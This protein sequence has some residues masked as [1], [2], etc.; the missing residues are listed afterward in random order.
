MEVKIQALLFFSSI[1]LII[2]A[3]IFFRISMLKYFGFYEPDGYYHYSIIVQ[4]IENGFRFPKYDVLSG[5]P[6]HTLFNTEPEGLYW[7]TLLPYLFLRY[8]GVS[9]YN[10]MRLVPVAYGIADIVGAYFLSRYLSKNKIFSLLVLLFVSLSLGDAAR[11]S[12]LIYRGDGFVTIFLIISL[13][14][15][16]KVFKSSNWLESFSFAFLSAVFLSLCNF[17]WNGAPFATAIYYISVGLIISLSFIFLNDKDLNNSLYAIAAIVIWY[18]ISNLYKA[19]DLFLSQTFTGK[20][21]ISLILFLLLGWILAKSMLNRKSITKHFV[22][23][24]AIVISFSILVILLARELEPA[25]FYQ[26]FVGNGFIVTNSFSATIEEL[27]SP[28]A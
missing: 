9:V 4:V 15:L 20:Y 25:L 7:V 26:V 11:T 22:L 23:R 12:A 19:W 6:Q 17:V 21:F 16:V 2:L 28:T 1:A 14:F 5:W 18:V 27:Q 10:V 8:F 13:I 24:G 3:G